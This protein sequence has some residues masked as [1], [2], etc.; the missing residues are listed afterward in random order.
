M[1]VLAFIALF[2]SLETTQTTVKETDNTNI[3]EKKEMPAP[4]TKKQETKKEKT[5]KLF[6]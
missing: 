3:T 2:F 5:I 1:E 6:M 4:C